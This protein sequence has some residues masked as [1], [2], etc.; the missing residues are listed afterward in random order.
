MRDE[1]G[2][3]V[4][5]VLR[6]VNSEIANSFSLSKITSREDMYFLGKE[7]MKKVHGLQ[8]HGDAEV[9]MGRAAGP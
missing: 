3:I 7:A 2:D 5:V 4:T 6:I 9:L 1:G 8:L